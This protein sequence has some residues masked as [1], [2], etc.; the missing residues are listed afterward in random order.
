[1]E[2]QWEHSLSLME[3]FIL[4]LTLHYYS[5]FLRHSLSYLAKPTW[6]N[7][8]SSAFHSVSVWFYFGVVGSFI[9]ILIQLILLIDFAHSWNKLWLENAENSDNKCWFAG[10]QG[11]R[12]YILTWSCVLNDHVANNKSASHSPLLYG[13]FCFNLQ[14]CCR[15]LYST[16]H[17]PL[18]LWCF[19]SF[20]TLNLMTAQ[21]TRSSSA[22][23][24]YSVSSSPPSASCPRYR[25]I[26]DHVHP[27]AGP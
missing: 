25:Y 2:L 23:T 21:S 22:S 17:W 3:R 14:A 18:P 8:I 9:F 13:R 19:F 15:S 5:T 24:S 20:T 11:T 16:M 12:C 10:T 4:V 7:C 1:M 6:V 27:T 26:L